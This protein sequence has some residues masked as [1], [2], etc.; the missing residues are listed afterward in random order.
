MRKRHISSDRWLLVRVLDLWMDVVT[1]S[2]V[3]MVTFP[4][5]SKKIGLCHMDKARDDGWEIIYCTNTMDDAIRVKTSSINI[6]QHISLDLQHS[7][8]KLWIACQLQPHKKMSGCSEYL[9]KYQVKLLFFQSR[10]IRH[11]DPPCHYLHNC[12]DGWRVHTVLSQV[13]QCGR[14]CKLYHG[15]G[16]DGILMIQHGINILFLKA[17]D[18][19]NDRHDMDWG[20]TKDY[21]LATCQE[22]RNSTCEQWYWLEHNELMDGNIQNCSRMA[23]AQGSA[24]NNWNGKETLLL[25][26]E[27]FSSSH[28]L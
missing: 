23:A 2:H 28:L 10:P 14:H 18:N 24:E 26:F 16:N 5:I 9:V 8:A 17:M 25:G 19:D 15:K 22:R 3:V 13:L 6:L 7:N 12:F 21:G 11:D 4:I 27:L 1:C 20:R